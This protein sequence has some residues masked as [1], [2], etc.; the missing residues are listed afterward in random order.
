[1]GK[2]S[3]KV[4][5]FLMIFLLGIPPIIY[6]AF[7][8]VPIFLQPDDF[9]V[10]DHAF[11]IDIQESPSVGNEIFI[12]IR[13]NSGEA[14]GDDYENNNI[15]VPFVPSLDAF[16]LTLT[17][18]I[19]NPTPN[20]GTIQVASDDVIH[21]EYGGS[22]S[23]V[24]FALAGTSYPTG[25]RWVYSEKIPCPLQTASGLSDPDGNP[26][27]DGD[28]ICDVWE[29][30]ESGN[31][32]IFDGRPASANPVAG[33]YT[34][35]CALTGGCGSDKPDI[36][37]EVDYMKGHKP[38]SVAMQQVVDAFANARESSIGLD[39]IRLH[40]QQE[41]TFTINHNP[42]TPFP[43]YEIQGFPGYRGF[44]QIKGDHF[45]TITERTNAPSGD[46]NDNERKLK[47]QVFHYTLF[48]HERR[49]Y[50]TQS[51]VGE[52][53][54]N[55]FMI[56]LGSFTGQVGSTD[57]QAGTF[58]H[59]LGHNLGLN[60]GGETF[61]QINNKPNYFSVMTYTRQF[62]DIDANRKLDFSNKTLGHHHTN[63]DQDPNALRPSLVENILVERSIGLDP[64]EGHMSGPPWEVIIFSCPDGQVA[65]FWS[66]AGMKVDWN[67]SW[68]WTW[69]FPIYGNINNFPSAPSSASNERLY[70]WNDWKNL[71]YNFTDNISNYEDGRHELVAGGVTPSGVVPGFPPGENIASLQSRHPQA[72]RDTGF[73]Y[74]STEQRELTLEMVT[75][76]RMTGQLALYRTLNIIPPGLYHSPYAAPTP[77]SGVFE[78]PNAEIINVQYSIK[79]GTL[80]GPDIDPKIKLPKVL[81][82]DEKN[83]K[84]FLDAVKDA[85]EAIN[86]HDIEKTKK[87]VQAIDIG[88]AKSLHSKLY[89]GQIK[90][91]TQNLILS[92]DKALSF[93]P[94]TEHPNTKHTPLSHP[95]LNPARID[96]FINDVEDFTKILVSNLYKEDVDNN[97]VPDE[98]DD[99]DG[100]LD[101][102]DYC[103]QVAGTT[104]N[105]GCSSWPPPTTSED[106]DTIKIPNWVK[107]NADWWSKGQIGD[108]DFVS[109]IQFLIKEGIIKIPTPKQGT[110]TTNVIPTWIQNN[111]K[112]WSEGSIN[113]KEFTQSIQWL[114][115]KGIMKITR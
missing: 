103:P 35:N 100:I 24:T 34:Y 67:C 28:G 45:G 73:S 48:V 96:K 59:E 79:N 43:G 26:D 64:Y 107:I 50:A 109:G 23:S 84:S 111:A 53:G 85:L 3:N 9:T 61:D 8:Q 95:L 2:S 83:K 71:D 87:I 89:N 112:W 44:D 7:A 99:K 54:G 32:V 29:D 1:M 22:S 47:H 74:I 37:V 13:V 5:A 75:L 31:L 58:M 86:H 41:N 92:Y 102:H 98:D 76:N 104:K 63:P 60:H 80:V 10:Q 17:P 42:H 70:G 39:G 91:I 16:S 12:T 19:A 20:D 6:P 21:I 93:S 77:I 40:L 66:I 115:E 62:A 106:T 110:S 113:D 55:D 51:G 30:D 114:I 69:D 38:D 90:P 68:T 78:E 52:V 14:S 56:S 33:T 94:T 57:Q 27:T 72:Q 25:T 18:V 15:R 65:P 82:E 49:W 4:I 46:W 36:F 88:L 101:I 11:R 105:N 81:V 108:S 97:N